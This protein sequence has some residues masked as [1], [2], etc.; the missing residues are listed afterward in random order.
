V[1]ERRYPHHRPDLP[2]HNPRLFAGS[3]FVGATKA[4]VFKG[5]RLG[6]RRPGALHAA[7]LVRRSATP[8]GAPARR[9]DERSFFQGWRFF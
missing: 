8:P 3:I 1:A 2:P 4:I 7:H 5:V 6:D 9:I